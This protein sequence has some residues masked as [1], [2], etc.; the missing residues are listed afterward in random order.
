MESETSPENRKDRAF[1]E[2]DRQRPDIVS[3][4]SDL[5]GRWNSGPAALHEHDYGLRARPGQRSLRGR[6][7]AFAAD[8][9]YGTIAQEVRPRTAVWR[10]ATRSVR[11]FQTAVL[12]PA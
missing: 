12:K 2:G 8:F 6:V 9:L 3:D 5:R 4:T 11:R 10:V 1:N 7:V